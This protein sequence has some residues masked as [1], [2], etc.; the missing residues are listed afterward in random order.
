MKRRI[1]L[2]VIDLNAFE[3]PKKRPLM[4]IWGVSEDSQKYVLID[5]R[6]LP[7]F[8]V[9]PKRNTNIEKLIKDITHISTGSFSIKKVSIEEKK[10]YR[11]KKKV[12]RCETYA[13]STTELRK[14]AQAVKELKGVEDVFEYDIRWTTQYLI[15]NEAKPSAWWTCRVGKAP[16]LPFQVARLIQPLKLRAIKSVEIDAPPPLTLVSWSMMPWQPEGVV[17]EERDPVVIAGFTTGEEDFMFDFMD[18]KRLLEMFLKAFRRIDPDIIFTFP[19]LQN[20]WAYFSRRFEKRNMMFLAGRDLSEP[21]QSVYGHISITGRA[22]ISLLD[23]ARETP[24]LNAPHADELAEHIGLEPSFQEWDLWD[25]AHLWFEHRDR[26]KQAFRE[27][28]A[29]VYELGIHFFPHIYALSQITGLPMDH[30]LTAGSGFRV[31]HFL[32]HMLTQENEIIPPRTEARSF[33]YEGGIVVQPPVGL[34][35]DVGV[36]DFKSMYPSIMIRYNISPETYIH[37]KDIKDPEKVW[38]T[39]STD[40]AFL[41]KPKGFIPRAISS[42]IKWR[43]TLQ[44]E[45]EASQPDSA[46]YQ[47]LDALQ[48]NVKV[49]T[50]SMYGYTAWQG[51]RWYAPHLA[52]ATTDWARHILQKT[53]EYAQKLGLKVY[54]CDTDS[55]FV[56]YDADKIAEL[57]NWVAREW[58][59][60][61]ELQK[62]YA[63]ILFTEAKKKYAAL[64]EDGGIEMVGVEAVR[65]DWCFFTRSLQTT[66]LEFILRKKNVEDGIRFIRARIEHLLQGDVHLHDMVIWKTLSKRVE[67]YK[68]KAPHVEVARYLAEKG[69]PMTPGSRVGYIVTKGKGPLYRR[70]KPYFLVDPSEIDLDYYLK[71]Q[72]LPPLE[73]VLHAIKSEV[74]VLI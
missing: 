62:R 20:E 35:E 69:Y 58:D 3:Q 73:R 31:E 33:H 16:E 53:L 36:L 2:W 26:V 70:A 5:R 64:R 29:T 44:K 42:L 14:L 67:D 37:A 41:K 8:F 71:K 59:L 63:R 50:N 27:R 22:N 17:H 40:H 25:W 72:I 47:L 49:I 56:S 19:I 68:I 66:L 30:V 11:K 28:L 23:I 65:S 61:I 32:I 1:R 38:K 7:R 52:E 54:Y 51:A 18:E 45:M 13:V 48:K 12:L 6:H 43:H 57:Q 15:D 24:E 34:F 55:L 10:V 46:R 60:N 21:H 4:V 9:L 39:P 74:R